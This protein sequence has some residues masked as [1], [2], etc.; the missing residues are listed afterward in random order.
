MRSIHSAIFRCR[1]GHP[2]SSLAQAIHAPMSSN[3]YNQEN[4]LM[5]TAKSE[6]LFFLTRTLYKFHLATMCMVYV[7]TKKIANILLSAKEE[8]KRNK[9]N[10][11]TATIKNMSKI[12]QEN[13]RRIISRY[14][15]AKQAPYWKEGNRIELMNVEYDVDCTIKGLEVCRRQRK[16]KQLSVEKHCAI[17]K[18]MD[19]KD[20][21]L[22]SLF[23]FLFLFLS[24]VNFAQVN[25]R[26]LYKHCL[27]NISYSRLFFTYFVYFLNITFIKL[28]IHF[29]HLLFHL[30]YLLYTFLFFESV[31]GNEVW[32]VV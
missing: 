19:K 31:F 4:V 1:W 32:Y 7:Q 10:D 23:H 20:E 22:N 18:R 27:F 12:K 5:F 24:H 14:N 9:I 2:I 15:R 26:F 25:I 13:R 11:F 16:E 17:T 6:K 28:L 29:S 30:F 21:I 3:I 8:K